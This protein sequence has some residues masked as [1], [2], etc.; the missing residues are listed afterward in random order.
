MTAVAAI[1]PTFAFTTDA[2]TGK[3]ATGYGLL[4]LLSSDSVLLPASDAESSITKSPSGTAY[5]PKA[6]AL[7]NSSTYGL[8]SL[9]Y[10]Q[11]SDGDSDF[12]ILSLFRNTAQSSAAMVTEW[13]SDVANFFSVMHIIPIETGYGSDNPAEGSYRVL[14]SAIGTASSTTATYVSEGST[15]T[16]Q[17]VY[18]QWTEDT[19]VFGTVD[20]KK[21][22]V[23]FEF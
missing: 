3:G 12:L 10:I 5:V 23:R 2:V 21:F 9:N 13:A 14:E 22:E 6:F 7:K 20:G 1:V 15:V 4:S 18:A 19:N 16:R 17:A 11:F 8:Y